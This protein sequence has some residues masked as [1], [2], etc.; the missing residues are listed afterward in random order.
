MWRKKSWQRE[1]SSAYCSQTCLSLQQHQ[2]EWKEIQ[3]RWTQVTQVLLP[4]S[5]SICKMVYP[6]CKSKIN[7]TRCLNR[8][9]FSLQARF[10]LFFTLKSAQK[11]VHFWIFHSFGLQIRQYS[12]LI[13]HFFALVTLIASK[14]LIVRVED[15]WKWFLNWFQLKLQS[16]SWIWTS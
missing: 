10:F 13:R 14:S 1:N 8:C 12:K 5:L 7:K 2:R 6:N 9:Q 16:F 3:N 11:L 4:V 15:V